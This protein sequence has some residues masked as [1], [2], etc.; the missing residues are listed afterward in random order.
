[1]KKLMIALAV[2]A[3]AVASQAAT[4]KWTSNAISLT[5]A[6]GTAISALPTGT[7]LALVV[8]NTATGWDSA[9]EISTGSTIAINSREGVSLGRVT[10]TLTFTYTEG[11]DID[12]GKYLALMF[13]DSEGLHQL[14]YTSGANE[15]AL[16]DAAWQISGLVNNAT[17]LSNKAIPMTGNFAAPEPTSAMLLLLGL[18]GLALKRKQA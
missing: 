1:M 7:T 3:M 2:A 17:S 9:T 18:A 8:M 12:N 14:T 11:G 16:V 13:K 5:D 6:E 4:I 10:G 15:G